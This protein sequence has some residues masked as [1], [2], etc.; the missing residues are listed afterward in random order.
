MRTPHNECVSSDITETDASGSNSGSAKPCAPSGSERRCVLSGE[1]YPREELIRLAVSPDGEVLPDPQGK[2]PGR[3]AWIAP[4]R[5][6][7][8]TAMTD[9]HLKKALM[10]SFKGGP[11]TQDGNRA[12]L[13]YSDNLAQQI[14]DALKRTL[15]DRLGLE[16]RGGNIV[17][18]SAKLAEHARSGRIALL[19][20]ASDSSE[21]GR[22]KLDQAFRVGTDQEG[23]G[24][25]GIVLPLDREALSVALG[26]ENV[27][28]LGVSGHHGGS[29]ARKSAFG[30]VA[31][32]VTRLT[33]F[34]GND[35]PV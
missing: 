25:R 1:T 34:L 4:D 12:R 15:L 22:K 31:R 10:R 8:E 3:G 5:L 32:D 9:G 20:H 19:L 13:S 29:L 23:S 35:P 18:G 17:M 2:A 28:H 14:E 33:R 21:D 24:V 16:L 30:R 27:V 26:R 6:T 7:L 11:A